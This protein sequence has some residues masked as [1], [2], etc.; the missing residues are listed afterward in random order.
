ML[1][2]HSYETYKLFNIHHRSE[3][4]AVLTAP[5][6]PTPEA[7]VIGMHWCSSPPRACVCDNSAVRRVVLE[8]LV[9]RGVIH[10]AEVFSGTRA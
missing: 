6:P 7:R 10:V 4:A 1:Y 2:K 5:V 9:L 8:P 3:V